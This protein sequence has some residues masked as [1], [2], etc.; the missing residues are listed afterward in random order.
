MFFRLP[1]RCQHLTAEVSN[2]GV[3]RVELSDHNP[4]RK[5]DVVC[6]LPQLH[7]SCLLLLARQLFEALVLL[8]SVLLLFVIC[9]GVVRVIIPIKALW[10]FLILLKPIE[11]VLEVYAFRDVQ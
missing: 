9:A 11:Y 4:T 2:F 3:Q 10:I 5:S 8:R 7:D 6:S 1:R